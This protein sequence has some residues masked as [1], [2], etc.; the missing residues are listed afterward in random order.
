[1]LQRLTHPEGEA[2]SLIV[3]PQLMRGEIEGRR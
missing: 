2:Q 1:M 3:P